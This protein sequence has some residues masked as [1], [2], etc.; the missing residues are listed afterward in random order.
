[1]GS[2]SDGNARRVSRSR[3]IPRRALL[4]AGFVAASALSLVSPGSAQVAAARNGIPAFSHVFVVVMENR[5]YAEA[6]AS[7][8][9]AALANRWALA[10]RYYGVAHPSLPNY[11]AMTG[12]STFG[13]TSDCVDCHVSASNLM[14][15]LASAHISY[16]A[17][18]E[19][20]PSA[21]YLAPWGGVGYASKHNPFRYFRNVRSSTAICSH[22]RP[23]G[24]LA[25]VL[26]KP[27][28][29][30][31][32]F[33]WVTPNLCHDGHDCSSQVAATWL[34]GFVSQVTASAAWKSGGVLFVTWDE[35]EGD[36]SAVSSS[37]QVVGSGGG[38]H[39][40]TI[41]IAP[42]LKHGARI[43]TALNHYSLLATI[44]DSFSLARLSHARTAANFSALFK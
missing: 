10:T 35:G 13:V 15:Q 6:M 23:Y 29:S 4:A 17:Y 5:T 24:E 38:G 12:G 30:V 34:V 37:G 2:R 28:S 41:V 1:M 22:L 31:P 20:V 33:V 27:A 18:L 3:S 7:T 9:I 40:A 42:T 11:L 16:D 39:V 19:G 26:K 25:G 8:P 21:C 14:G 32:R 44:E 36:S 43:A